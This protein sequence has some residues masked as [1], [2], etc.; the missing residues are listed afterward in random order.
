MNGDRVP[1]AWGYGAYTNALGFMDVGERTY[2]WHVL[3][4]MQAQG[5]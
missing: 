5:V 2:G 3:W 1:Q 4:M